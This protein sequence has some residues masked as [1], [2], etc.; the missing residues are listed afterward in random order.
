MSVLE[1]FFDRSE[2][3]VRS[4]SSNKKDVVVDVAYNLELEIVDV[5]A[6]DTP[7]SVVGTLSTVTGR[8]KTSLPTVVTTSAYGL[9]SYLF[10]FT[11]AT[12]DWNGTDDLL[13]ELEI[14]DNE[15]Y[16][17]IIDYLVKG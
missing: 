13:L 11:I 14:I 12:A 15:S 2:F 8:V 1:D 4:K 3:R 10:Q 17:Y 5:I 16:V 7:A 9:S 6:L